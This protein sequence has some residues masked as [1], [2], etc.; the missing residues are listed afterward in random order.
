MVP[1][2]GGEIERGTHPYPRC[3]VAIDETAYAEKS[4]IGGLT[5]SDTHSP[6]SRGQ[7]IFP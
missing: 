3:E 2:V 7:R 4:R 6:G 5:L 1:G